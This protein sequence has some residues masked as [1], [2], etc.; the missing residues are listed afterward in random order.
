MAKLLQET[1]DGLLQEIGDFILLDVAAQEYTRSG[2]ALLGLLDSYSR[3]IQL[4]RSDTSLL[5]LLGLKS[6]TIA[7]S[8]S[9]EA[10]LGLKGIAS[11]V[12]SI[13]RADV[14]SLGLKTICSMDTFHHYIKEATAYLDLKATATRDTVFAR[15]DIALLGLK[16]TATKSIALTRAKVALLGLKG[17]ASR[18]ISLSRSSTALLEL[19]TG[20]KLINVGSEAKERV[21][22]D[23]SGYTRI[24][25]DKTANGSGK[26]VAVE[27]FA[28]QTMGGVKVGIFYKTNGNTL[29]CRSAATIGIVT[30]GSK[31]RFSVSLA[32]ETGDYIGIY[33]SS[34]YISVDT[35][36]VGY[37]FDF[38]P[39]D[40]CIVDNETTYIFSDNKTS[41]LYGENFHESFRAISYNRTK[42]ALLGLLANASRTITFTRVKTALLGLKG[43]AEAT[44]VTVGK[45]LSIV[46]TT[47]P[48]RNIKIKTSLYRSVIM[49]IAQYR[50]IIVRTF[51]RK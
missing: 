9:D 27:I 20:A 35:E 3:A 18:A 32:I 12:I 31:Q 8:R 7:L 36:G 29:K 6:R 51:G 46:V 22:S 21:G 30:A 16:A 1:G 10:L 49:R 19:N 4:T 15:A 26:I 45:Y 39:G 23:G 48:Y 14:A 42:I 44:Y 5:G 24:A 40:R 34:G 41:S 47:S 13:T 37:W 38:V 2:T 11:R 28:A 33:W 50:D 43:I 25:G 17:I